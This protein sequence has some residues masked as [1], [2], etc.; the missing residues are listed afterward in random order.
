MKKPSLRQRAEALLSTK[1][2]LSA[3]FF[4]AKELLH[5]LMVH[6]VELEMQ[7]EE[8]RRSQ[9][10][11]IK[12]RE[13]YRLLFDLA[14]CGYIVLDKSGIVLK[15]NK[16]AEGFFDL[17]Q[18]EMDGRPIMLYILP[19]DHTMLFNVLGH[20]FLM[21]DIR[22]SVLQFSYK[23]KPIRYIRI[24]CRAVAEGG[25]SSKCLCTMEDIT[26]LKE[27]EQALESAREARR[28]VQDL[29]SANQCLRQTDEMK[30]DFINS[31]SHELRT[32]LTSILG[33][34]KI[35]E[36]DFSKYFAKEGW[37]NGTQQEKGERIRSNLKIIHEESGRLGTLI[38][39]LL[40][41]GMIESGNLTWN[42]QE[43]SVAEV[44]T[45][46]LDGLHGLFREK[47]EVKL[48]ME[49]QPDLPLL[50]IDPLRLEQVLINLISNA[51]KHTDKGEIGIKACCRDGETLFFQ[52]AD[53]GAGIERHLLLEVFGKFYQGRLL[54]KPVASRGVGLGL[55]ICQQIVEHYD[56]Y[57]WA[58]SVVG[59]G[60]VVNVE[61]PC[62][63][64]AT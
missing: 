44:V 57:I 39:D 7:N 61:L 23:D 64:A 18:G 20:A 8:L 25:E 37:E 60:T 17:K 29:E 48:R 52:V 63:L 6:Q 33:F 2:P 59:Q 31:V 45:S 22:S 4:S 5:E 38:D 19:S 58:E 28:K 46:T 32:P 49:V 1:E 42:D 40:D 11:T 26:A 50:R 15:A 54:L 27:R 21:G 53:S 41:L 30:T 35:V 47:P 56:G 55:S 34:A 3:D 62:T 9:R 14:P 10:E 16:A 36:R 12:A 13:S 43:T 51:F 24:Q